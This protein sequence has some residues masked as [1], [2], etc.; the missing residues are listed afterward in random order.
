MEVHTMC[1]TTAIYQQWNQHV[2][3]K[4]ESYNY[5][6]VL[7]SCIKITVKFAFAARVRLSSNEWHLDHKFTVRHTQ[8]CIMISCKYKALYRKQLDMFQ[9][10]SPRCLHP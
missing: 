3:T 10:Y 1:S 9:R 8:L 2:S 7:S 6:W 4:R 5:R